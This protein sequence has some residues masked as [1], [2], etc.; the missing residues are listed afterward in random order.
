MP[1]TPAP[2]TL[3]LVLPSTTVSTV[4]TPNTAN[5]HPQP[6]ATAP[7]NNEATNANVKTGVGGTNVNALGTRLGKKVPAGKPHTGVGMGFCRV[8]VRVWAL[9]PGG[10]P[11][12]IPKL[13]LLQLE[14]LVKTYGEDSISMIVDEG[15]YSDVRVD[16]LTP[17]G[18]SSR[19]PKH[20]GIGILASV[21]TELEASP[22]S[23]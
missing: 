2:A 7:N 8:R 9:V 16:V 4:S 22:L 5:F 21:V 3:W 14:Y 1:P 18:H 19:P 20:T 23:T 13:A 12:R 11:V 10:L 17:G 6:F 15:G